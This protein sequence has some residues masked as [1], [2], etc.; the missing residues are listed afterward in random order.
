M[1]YMTSNDHSKSDREKE[2]FAKLDEV[3]KRHLEIHNKHYSG[4]AT[5][6]K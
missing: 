3:R 6:E 1:H 2:L 5:N 4:Q